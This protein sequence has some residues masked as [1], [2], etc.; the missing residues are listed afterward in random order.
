M[1][2]STSTGSH[3]PTIRVQNTLEREKQQSNEDGK[4]EE[5]RKAEGG[6]ENVKGEGRKEQKR[7]E[8]EKIHLLI[9]RGKIQ[10][11]QQQEDRNKY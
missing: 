10:V 1:T 6:E 3:C 7:K 8:K 9:P 4:K 11:L 2:A 5:N